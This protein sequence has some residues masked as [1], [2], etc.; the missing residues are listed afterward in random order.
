M[1][2]VLFAVVGLICARYADSAQCACAT[3][4]VAVKGAGTYPTVL[5]ILAKGNCLTLGGSRWGI[6]GAY[7]VNVNYQGQVCMTLY[8]RTF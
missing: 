5:T 3:T 7:W 4:S 1:Y 8:F 6:P 2:L